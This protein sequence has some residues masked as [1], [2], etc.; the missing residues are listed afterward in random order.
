MR[1]TYIFE[2]TD[3]NLRIKAKADTDVGW[4]LDEQWCT[5]DINDKII[6]NKSDA[7]IEYITGDIP[8][9]DDDR[10][11]CY[12]MV[13]KDYA[14]FTGSIGLYFP[15]VD[16]DHVNF[17][18]EFISNFPLYVSSIGLIDT[19]SSS[20]VT[21][22]RRLKNMLF[23][24]TRHV[25]EKSGV[26]ITYRK[27]AV[28]FIQ[29]DSIIRHIA[30][31]IN[32][33]YEFFG[34]SEREKF[35][36]NYNGMIVEPGGGTGY[37]GNGNYAGFNFLITEAESK[38]KKKKRDS[39]K[40]MLLHELYHHFNKSGGY[41]SNWFGEGFTEFFCRYLS[42]SE[43]KFKDE[44]N[45]F[46]TQYHMN[47]YRNSGIEIMTRHNFWNNKFVEKLPYA[48]GFVYAFYL[49][50]KY[51]D[52]FIERYKKIITDSYNDPLIR[53]DNALLKE[54]LKDEYFDRYIINGETIKIRGESKIN[55]KSVQMGFDIDDAINNKNISHIDQK[56]DAYKKGV[57]NGSIEELHINMSD[58]TVKITQNK[59]S[60]IVNIL[61]G[62]AISVPQI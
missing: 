10:L 8:E 35:M 7:Y 28:F 19:D 25:V 45:K 14:C 40:I 9:F 1:I 21:D 37:G 46:L 51:G 59:K 15:L 58:G 42:L 62:K 38:I 6:I 23:V 18:V 39:I 48:K 53:L 24:F 2:L 44:C 12:P 60:M 32:S 29:V 17:D 3:D 54:Y 52:I 31:F 11:Y 47:P 34:I 27:D 5:D 13:R 36:I 20:F 49:L 57:R 50:Q 4:F 55:V 56:S 30:K 26:M 22:L 43:S 41:E 16:D 61:K 33:C